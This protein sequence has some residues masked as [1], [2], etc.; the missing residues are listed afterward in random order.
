M[1]RRHSGATA[2]SC[3][4]KVIDIPT[5]VTT[6][7]AN[8]SLDYNATRVGPLESSPPSMSEDEASSAAFYRVARYEITAE[9]DGS[10]AQLGNSRIV[11][12]MMVRIPADAN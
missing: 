11:Q 3:D 8:T 7:P 10:D 1:R 4:A 9:F 12:G 2:N 5:S 6:T